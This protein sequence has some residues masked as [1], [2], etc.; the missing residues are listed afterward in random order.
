MKNELRVVSKAEL[1]KINRAITNQVKC[2]QW[3]NTQTVVD[4]FKSIS[5]KTKAPF[6][7]FD[8]AA[9]YPSITENLTLYPMHKH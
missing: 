4:W 7:K 1:E 9:F 8:I 6:K 2:N 3:H 5:D